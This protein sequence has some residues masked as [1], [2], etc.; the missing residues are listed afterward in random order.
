MSSIS[1]VASQ[2]KEFRRRL[3][4]DD[5]DLDE[6]TLADTLEGLT[7]LHEILA[8]VIRE[9]LFDEAL[10]SGL[11]QRIDQMEERQHRLDNQAAKR[12]QLVREVMVE[13]DIK[14]LV[15]PEFTVSIRAG[16][17]SVVVVDEFAIPNKFWEPREPRLDKQ[18]VWNEL[19]G[20][21]DIPGVMLSNPEPV[22][23]VRTR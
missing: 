22:M 20:G 11:K 23:S 8:A 14:K 1:L 4:L 16:T 9:V 10:C 7:D 3:L 2:H 21:A 13:N 19:K 12:R 5:P 15:D 17:A 6:R 18:R